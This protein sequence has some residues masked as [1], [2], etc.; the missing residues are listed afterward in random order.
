VAYNFRPL[1]IYCTVSAAR[2][3]GDYVIVLSVLL[4]HFIVNIAHKLLR[5]AFDL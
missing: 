2:V 3:G 4:L 5:S 1:C